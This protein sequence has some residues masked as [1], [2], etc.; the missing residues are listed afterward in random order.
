MPELAH[1]F[2]VEEQVDIFSVASRL[3]LDIILSLPAYNNSSNNGVRFVDLMGLRTA[4]TPNGL[5]GEYLDF[6]RLPYVCDFSAL[7]R[8]SYFSFS[9][10]CSSS[11]QSKI[12]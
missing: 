3:Q 1:F 5:T 9:V 11:V 2:W 10:S 8:S 4:E 12:C 6:N 7:A